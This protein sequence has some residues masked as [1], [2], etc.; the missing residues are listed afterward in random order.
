MRIIGRN[1]SRTR[2]GKALKDGAVAIVD[3]RCVMF[4]LAEERVVRRKQAGGFEAAL[5]RAESQT[6]IQPAGSDWHAASS[7]CEPQIELRRDRYVV[8]NHHLS[9]ASSA[10][11]GSP[12]DRAL[13]AVIDAGGNVLKNEMEDADWWKYPREQHSYFLG[14]GNSLSLLARE[15]SDAYDM[16]LGEF[17][18][19]V[20]HFLGWNSSEYCGNVMALA[21]LGEIDGQW[22]SAFSTETGTIR[23]RIRNEPLKPEDTIEAFLK[24]NGIRIMRRRSGEPIGD[25]HKAVARWAQYEVEKAFFA[26]LRALMEELSLFNLCIAGGFAL[27]CSLTG[28]LWRET[29]VRRVFIPLSP[30]DTGQAIGNAL[31]VRHAVWRAG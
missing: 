26:R 18:R 15:C 5:R 22:P 14:E 20:T 16:G 30:G 9:H 25:Q 2:Y 8:V 4:A 28:K 24:A 6:G 19:A 12:F 1:Q 17:Y 13:V 29:P 23:P 27:N 7:C 21:A 3:E 10:F 31:F 11:F